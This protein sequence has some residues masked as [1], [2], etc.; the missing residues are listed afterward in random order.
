MRTFQKREFE[1]NIIFLSA[2][3]LT[4][5]QF[6]EIKYFLI[7]PEISNLSYYLS[8]TFDNMAHIIWPISHG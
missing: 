3:C 5:N 8:L 6:Y 7:S 2:Q 4:S 1:S